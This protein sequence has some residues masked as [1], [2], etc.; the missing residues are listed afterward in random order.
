M[1]PEF[2]W[3]MEDILALYAEPYDPQYPVVCVDES[4]YQLVSEV[5]HPLPMVP[6]GAGSADPV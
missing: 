1:S 5:R 6:D 2:V 3:R 4:P